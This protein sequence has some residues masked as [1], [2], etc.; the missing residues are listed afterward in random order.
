MSN[1]FK[2]ISSGASNVFKKIDKGSDNLFKKVSS[3]YKKYSNNNLSNT[4][5]DINEVQSPHAIDN[6]KIN[7]N[8]KFRLLQCNNCN[9][10]SSENSNKS[11]FQ[12]C[13]Y[14]NRDQNSCANMLNIVNSYLFNNRIRPQAFCK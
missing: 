7:G 14:L 8:S 3:Y 5:E 10:G 6:K 1:F 13:K 2:K 9:V 12:F 11:T 4:V